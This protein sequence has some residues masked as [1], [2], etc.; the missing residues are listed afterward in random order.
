MGWGVQAGRGPRGRG[1]R[2]RRASILRSRL[3][4]ATRAHGPDAGPSL[5]PAVCQRLAGWAGLPRPL[6]LRGP[7]L[8]IPFASVTA[9]FTVSLSLYLSWLFP[10]LCPCSQRPL[11]GDLRVAP[12]A[13]RPTG[14]QGPTPGLGPSRLRARTLLRTLVVTDGRPGHAPSLRQGAS[15]PWFPEP[16]TP[17]RHPGRPRT[18]SGT[19]PKLGLC[20]PASPSAPIISPG[21]R[22]RGHRHF[23]KGE[24]KGSERGTNLP[25]DTELDSHGL[26]LARGPPTRAPCSTV[27]GHRIVGHRCR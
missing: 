3:T 5:C 8:L 27:S 17:H 24:S 18:G 6:S 13:S 4:W 14:D 20:R 19:D 21:G 12:G 15:A 2:G 25:E 1:Q 16:P 9:L 23:Y 11:P 26:L 10:A 7:F 22:W